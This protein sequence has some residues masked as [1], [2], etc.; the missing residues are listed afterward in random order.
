MQRIE[1]FL[2]GASGQAS[3]FLAGGAVILMMLLTCAD[4]AMRLFDRPIPGTY[5]IIGFLGTLA[6]AF[7]LAATSVEKGH[8]AVDLLANMLPPRLQIFLDAVSALLGILLFAAIAW[9]SALYAL[10]LR[11][12]GE[13]SPTLGMPI[14]PF[15]AG[16]A[17]GCALL[18]LVLAAELVRCLRRV[19][20]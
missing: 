3:S 2:N 7:A 20:S 19:I 9:Q 13:V 16:I 17:A 18:C 6:A 8:I 15:A 14:Y 10:D 11:A 5:E 4:V 12:S 1:R